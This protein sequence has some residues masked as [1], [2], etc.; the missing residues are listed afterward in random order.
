MFSPKRPPETWSA[1]AAI[2]ATMTGCASGTCIVA[3]AWMRW[4]AA[5]SPVAHVNPS[6]ERSPRSAA[7]PCP[8]QR[9]MGTIAS[10]PS[11]SAQRARRRFSSH[12][13]WM[14]PST[15]AS[16]T[17]PRRLI[18]KMP[19]FSALSAFRTGV[20]NLSTTINVLDNACDHISRTPTPRG[21][22]AKGPHFSTGGQRMADA[23]TTDSFLTTSRISLGEAIARE[24]EQEI[25]GGEL[26]PG[27]RLGTKEDLRARF[28]VALAT[29]NEAIRLLEMRGMLTARPGPGG[30]VFVTHASTR[31]R[32]NHF[33]MGY[34]WNEAAV[35]DHH[36][37]R[38]ALEPLVDRE[39]A[40]YRR[41]SDLRVLEH[42]LDTMENDAQ[43]PLTVL[44]HTWNLHRR[45]AKIIRN[46]PL[47][48]IYLTM[49][50]F[51]ED[52]V[53]GAAFKDFDASGHIAV[54]RGL[55]NG[56]ADG[57]GERLEAALREHEL[58]VTFDDED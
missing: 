52:A 32:L 10:S 9:A 55:V 45:I 20:W 1:V 15:S 50:D 12:V 36:A 46:Q 49:L 56:I 23:T 48:S 25:T 43:D 33:V 41:E 11:R 44:C 54:H 30:G 27:Q 28:G 7:P 4:V 24:L 22:F 47:R 21:T 13:P 8:R 35:A 53:E 40:K 38:N 6:N 16:V 2:L 57:P 51:L 42:M 58:S 17:P 34:K 5:M 18:P 3:K 19:T 14:L 29:I 26:S 39:A 31:A 37:V